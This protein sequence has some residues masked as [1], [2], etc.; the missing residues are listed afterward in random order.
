VF[1]FLCFGR[2]LCRIKISGDE[3]DRQGSPWRIIAGHCKRQLKRATPNDDKK[4]GRAVEPP[5]DLKRKSVETQLAVINGLIACSLTP[6]QVTQNLRWVMEEAVYQVSA[7]CLT[8]QCLNVHQTNALP[9]VL[10]WDLELVRLLLGAS[11]L[12]PVLKDHKASFS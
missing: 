12:V 2:D 3:R 10:Q 7:I 1:S 9:T 8:I 5:D 6:H 4:T 11:A